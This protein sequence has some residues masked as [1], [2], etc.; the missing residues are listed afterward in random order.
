MSRSYGRPRHQQQHESIPGRNPRSR[1]THPPRAAAARRRGSDDPSQRLVRAT[2]LGRGSAAPEDLPHLILRPIHVVYSHLRGTAPP[3]SANLPAAKH[4][5][6]S[7]PHPRPRPATRRVHRAAA[8]ARTWWPRRY[9]TKTIAP[10]AAKSRTRYMRLVERLLSAC[11][12]ATAS[13]ACGRGGVQLN[14]QMFLILAPCLPVAHIRL[15]NL[16]I[17]CKCRHFKIQ[18]QMTRNVSFRWSVSQESNLLK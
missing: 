14:R 16:K 4:M 7:P 6:R 1:P 10:A 11:R 13:E 15:H 18:S 8:R 2:R 5:R 12:N 9:E 3:P 17:G